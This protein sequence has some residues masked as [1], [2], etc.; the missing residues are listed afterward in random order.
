M[1]TCARRHICPPCFDNAIRLL[2]A[3]DAELLVSTVLCV[4]SCEARL[5]SERA[6]SFRMVQELTLSILHFDPFIGVESGVDEQYM[7]PLAEALHANTSLRRLHIPAPTELSAGGLH[8]LIS[9]VESSAVERCDVQCLDE[10][11][12]VIL[13]G[14]CRDNAEH[15]SQEGPS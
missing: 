5:I 4:L 6:S 9:A 2:R 13:D 12:Q 7:Q 14:V 1:S 11:N 8:T 15:R 3:N 10:D